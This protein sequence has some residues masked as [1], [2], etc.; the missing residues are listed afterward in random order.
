MLKC[1]KSNIVQ[2]TFSTQG[3]GRSRCFLSFD[4]FRLELGAGLPVG[5]LPPF[6]K[7][8]II[9]KTEQV[10]KLRMD[11]NIWREYSWRL[12]IHQ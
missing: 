3:T 5:S 6:K 7:A 11:G 1:Q 12:D 10:Q 8:C 4:V 2:F 9:A